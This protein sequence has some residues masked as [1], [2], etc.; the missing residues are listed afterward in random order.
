[1]KRY[2]FIILVSILPSEFLAGGWTKKAALEDIEI[3]RNQ[4]FQIKGEFGNPSN[5]TVSNTIFVS[6]EHPQ[7]QH[8]LAVSLSAFMGNKKLYIYSHSCIEY[9][10][11]GGSYNQLTNAGSMY[12][13]N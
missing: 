13:K 6:V 11:H 5:C 10:W 2:F 1:M 12:I 9:G 4:G 3:I 7:Y 8:L